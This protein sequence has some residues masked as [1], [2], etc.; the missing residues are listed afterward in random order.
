VSTTAPACHLEAREKE[1]DLATSL[2]S[3]CRLHHPRQGSL[4]AS[5]RKCCVP[6]ALPLWQS[7]LGPSYV[8]SPPTLPVLS[9]FSPWL[10]QLTPSDPN[11]QASTSLHSRCMRLLQRCVLSSIS[12]TPPTH[13]CLSAL[14]CGLYNQFGGVVLD[15]SESAHISKA[16]GDKKALIMASHGLLTVGESIER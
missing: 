10:L 6:L 7:F 9:R 12:R 5:Q 8:D 15:M 1:A 3:Q 4:G 16:L 14:D 2:S 11:R 13:P